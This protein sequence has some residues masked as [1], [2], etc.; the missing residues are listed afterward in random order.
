MASQKDPPAAGPSPTLDLKWS[1][2]LRV[3]TVALLCFVTVAAIALVG[4]YRD[5]RRGDESLAE[6]VVKQLQLQLLRINSNIDLPSRFPD[7]EPVTAGVQ[8]AGQCIRYVKEDGSLGRASCIGFDASSDG[9]P[10]WFASLSGWLFGPPADVVRPVSFRGNPNGTVIVTTEQ[11]V[12]LA[13]VWKDVSGLLG[14]TAL[15]IGAICL[16]QFVAIGRALRPTKEILAGLDKLAR[17]DLSCRLPSFRLVELQRISE[18]FN[19]LAAS[20]E[21]TTREKT[22]LAAK[23]VDNQEQERRHLARELHDELAQN[24]SAITAIAASIKATAA[25]E[26]VKLVPEASKLAEASMAIM[27]SLQTT[28]R[29]LRPPEI[30]DLGLAASLSAL[31]S[32]HERRAGGG[33]QISVEINGDLQALPP[34]AASHVYRIVQ[35]GL[36]NISKH[37]G[38]TRV[39]LALDICSDAGEAT[40]LTEPPGGP[41][42]DLMIEDD[43]R[44][45]NGYEEGSGLGLIGVRERVMALGGQLEAGS[46]AERG[47]KLH[48]RIPFAAAQGGLQ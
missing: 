10:H 25:T 45:A 17:G 8:T 30:D 27:K 40:S 41:W 22:A 28:L 11:A 12:V 13:A 48:T 33:L 7:W 31:A 42:L 39:R 37:A 38:A 36:T 23:L 34:T 46:G 15:V 3:V 44:G 35:E 16:L 26:C 29:T 24:L 5:V 9:A 1:L 14:L 43:G 20:L 18:V 19:R 6:I 47:F 2:T 21:L 32:E 4:T